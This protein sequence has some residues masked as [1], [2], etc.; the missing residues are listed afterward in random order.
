MRRLLIVGW[1]C[2]GSE[3]LAPA[4]L[5]EMPN[6]RAI[7]QAGCC[8]PLEST[9]PPIT[10]PA[11]TSMLTGRD[12]GELGLYGFRNRRTYGYDDTVYASSRMVKYPRL[13]DYVAQDGGRSIVVG[14][15]QTLPAPVVDGDLIAGFEG[16][17]ATSGCTYPPNLANEIPALADGYRYDIPDYRNV[18][19]ASILELVHAM[20]QRRAA[21]M[22]HLVTTRAWRF[23]MLCEIAPDRLHHC[24]WSDHDP[25]H[26]RHDRASP[27]R[28]VIRAYYR[29]LDVLLG[30]L[31]AAAGDDAAVLIASDHGAKAMHGGVCVNDVLRDAGWLVL[32]ET[33][34]EP[35]P[36]TPEMV[37]WT[38]TRAWGDGGYYARIFLNVA[39]RE[40]AGIVP[41]ERYDR[42]RDELA[43]LLGVVQ[44]RNG[45]RLE[46]AVVRPERAYRRVRG[47]APD[48]L[49]FFGDLHWRS[50]GS[51][52][53]A[54]GW[55]V[56]NDTGADE[57][58]H[59]RDGF[60]AFAGPGVR[61]QA[62]RRA[63]I[64]D[65]MPTALAWLGIPAPGDLCGRSLTA[66]DIAQPA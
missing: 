53:Y 12:P 15:P 36:F 49:V 16:E 64:L 21:I 46:N 14:V 9:V 62:P 34:P 40:P 29:E 47:L 24:F 7:A 25:S 65:I 28:G 55:L 31:I 8:G 41:P 10:V 58:N 20:T 44:L 57:A 66:E 4:S 18:D 42:T 5:A 32:K 6:L 17:G 19:R 23:A 61:R 59:A 51:V 43:E 54:D 27:Y 13:W 48:L 2:V 56:G 11:W 3:I 63:S 35:G 22:E 1:D 33:P 60:Y 38:R 52:G 45:P 37:D 30:R 50:L 26:P 39:G